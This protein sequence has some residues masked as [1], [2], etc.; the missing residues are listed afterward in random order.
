MPKK[1][2]ERLEQLKIAHETQEM[3]IR[4]IKDLGFEPP[5]KICQHQETNGE[6][7]ATVRDEKLNAIYHGYT[8]MLEDRDKYKI[9]IDALVAR[10]AEMLCKSEKESSAKASKR[11][12]RRRG[13]PWDR[14]KRR[15]R[16]PKSTKEQQSNSSLSNEVV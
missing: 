8:V 11:R 13:N 12:A 10:D 15:R 2:D 4:L 1:T 5:P 14:P 16:Q 7:A 3:M 9:E 6:K